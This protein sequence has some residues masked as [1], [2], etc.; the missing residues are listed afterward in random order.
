MVGIDDVARRAGVST[1]TVSRALSGRGH[2]AAATRERVE[3][4]AAEL[5]YVVSASASS[6]ATGRMRNIGVVVPFLKSWF[7]TSVLEG[8]QRR[9]MQY[10]YDLTLYNL[11]GSSNERSTVF[12]QFL[13]RQ[14]VDAVIAVSL[15]LS[16]EEVDSLHA[17]GKPLVGV[18]GPIRGVPTLSIDD[19]GVTRLATEHLLAL[20]HTVIGHIG[21]DVD[22]EMSFHMPTNRRLGWE[23]ALRD[24]GVEPRPELYFPAVFTLE[25]GYVAAKQMLGDPRLRPTAVVVASDEMAIGVILAARDMGLDVPRDLSVVGIDDHELASFFG[26]TT[27]AQFPEQQGERAVE[28]LMRE[29]EGPGVDDEPQNLQ[30]PFDLVVR[31]STA[32]PRPDRG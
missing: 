28:L 5:G 17:L 25:S 23:D 3:E 30:L 12:E 32:R 10:G 19:V 27:V 18:G 1:A 21:G 7:Y 15:E 9:L 14:R 20:G 24:A 16:G 4:A 29:L 22:A 8:A 26:L 31:G 6:L 11:S 13:L 2:V